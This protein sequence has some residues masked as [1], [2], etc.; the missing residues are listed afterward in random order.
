MQ[1]IQLPQAPMTGSGAPQPR[2]LPEPLKPRQSEP[3]QFLFPPDTAGMAKLLTRRKKQPS[4]L[5]PTASPEQ[6]ILPKVPSPTL[7]FPVVMTP[8]TI[9]SSIP[10]QIPQPQGVKR[11][12][13]VDLRSNK[14]KKKTVRCGQCGD[15]RDPPTHQ[16]YMGYRYCGKT[17]A[18]PFHQWRANLQSLGVARKKK[19]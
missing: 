14:P 2:M 16:Q 1:G 6:F 7:H 8:S 4:P 9:L 19:E 12:A 15:P 17:D 18:V 3:F 10:V 5:P 11:M 13:V